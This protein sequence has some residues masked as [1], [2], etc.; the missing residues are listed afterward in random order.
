VT[1]R[2]FDAGHEVPREAY[3]VIDQWLQ[4]HARNE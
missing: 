3:A 4:L 2:M 1:L